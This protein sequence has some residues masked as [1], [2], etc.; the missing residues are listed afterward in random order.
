ML[1]KELVN[2]IYIICSYLGLIGNY[3]WDIAILEL[4]KPFVL[5]TLLVPICIDPFTYGDQ[6]VLEPGSYGKVAGFGRTAAGEPSEIL[7]ALSVPYVPYSECKSAS[8]DNEKQK[9]IT[10]DKFCAGYTNGS[11][12]CDGDSGGGLAFETGGLWYLRGIVSVSLGT[13]EHGGSSH[14]DNNL[15]SLYTRISSHITWILDVV[16]R[17][18]HKRPYPSCPDKP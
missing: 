11:S 17:I 15:Y 7:Q 18:G 12:V 14:C 1:H 6:V 4:V 10:I 5:S 8:Q 16:D 9:Y 3:I 2:K 13:I